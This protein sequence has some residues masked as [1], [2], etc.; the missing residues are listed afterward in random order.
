L[1]TRTKIVSKQAALPAISG[2]VHLAKGWFDVL[3]AQH[4]RLLG[5]AKTADGTLVVLVYRDSAGRPVPL[6]AYDRAQMVAALECVDLVCIC[7]AS[8]AE[9]I[10][11]ALKPE[12]ELDVD[13][14]QTRDVVRDVLERHADR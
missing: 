7:D 1:D 13:A 4:G 6:G 3:T 10:A 12:T 9:S 8:R 14:L 11:A 5:G 2:S